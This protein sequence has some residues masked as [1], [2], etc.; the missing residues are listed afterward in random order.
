MLN[1]ESLK[2]K[3]EGL[4]S[5]FRREFVLDQLNKQ[6]EQ[7]NKQELGKV[8]QKKGFLFLIDIKQSRSSQSQGIKQIHQVEATLQRIH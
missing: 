6:Q 2:N 4:C 7:R 3:K 1:L 8:P 5:S